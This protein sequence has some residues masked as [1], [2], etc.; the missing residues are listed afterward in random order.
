MFVDCIHVVFCRPLGPA[1]GFNAISNAC[2][3]RV[4]SSSLNMCTVNLSLFHSI[5]QSINVDLSLHIYISV[6]V[7][8]LG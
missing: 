6:F 3:A 7:I 8:M 1:A 2:L 5:Y 4:P